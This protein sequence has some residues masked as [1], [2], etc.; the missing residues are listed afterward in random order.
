MKKLLLVFMSMF[1]VLGTS[2]AQDKEEGSKDF[3]SPIVRPDSKTPQTSVAQIYL[4]FSKD[5]V[6]PS[7]KVVSL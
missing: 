5:V 6:E 1:F 2:M 7:Q 3:N 4:T